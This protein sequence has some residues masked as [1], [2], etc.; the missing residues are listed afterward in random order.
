MTNYEIWIDPSLPLLIDVENQMWDG[1]EGRSQR[2]GSI[3]TLM[4]S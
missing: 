3:M 4:E 2:W 1:E